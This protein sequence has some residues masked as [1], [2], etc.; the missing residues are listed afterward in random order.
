MTE[1]A[2]AERP[3]ATG[4][5]PLLRAQ[6]LHKS[7]GGVHAV[8]DISLDVP[9]GSIFAIIGPNGAGKSTLLNLISG[10]YRPDS[11]SIS[12]DGQDLSGMSEHRRVGVWVARA[13][14]NINFLKEHCVI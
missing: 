10:I 2:A 9:T 1:A 13:F 12:L 14:Q 8:F 4:T 5:A 3:V 6:N 7:F 11:G